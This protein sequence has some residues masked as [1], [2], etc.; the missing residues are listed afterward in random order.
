MDKLNQAGA[1]NMSLS[2]AGPSLGRADFN[3]TSSSAIV[4][5]STLE[6]AHRA[7]LAVDGLALSYWVSKLDEAGP[8]SLTL[9]VDKA[10]LFSKQSLISRFVSSSFALQSWAQVD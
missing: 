3:F 6:P 1:S 10:A 9:E 8:V 4:A 7:V 2:Q 5:S